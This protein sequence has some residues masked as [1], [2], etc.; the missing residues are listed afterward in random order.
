MS[1]DNLYTYPEKRIAELV[2]IEAAKELKPIS[3]GGLDDSLVGCFRFWNN[4]RR[5]L[6]RLQ[7]IESKKKA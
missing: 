7:E 3:Q 5:A 6:D 4:L 1:Q 2:V